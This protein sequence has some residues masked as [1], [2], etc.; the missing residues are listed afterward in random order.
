MSDREFHLGDVLSVTTGILVSPSGKL[1]GPWDLVNHMT[2]DSLFTHQLPRAFDECAPEL[3]RQHPDL[4]AVTVPEMEPEQV[5]SW[6]AEQVAAFG[7]YRSV[8]PLAAEDH[9]RIDP[10]A[11]LRMMRPD[12]PIIA[13]T[14]HPTP[15]RSD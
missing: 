4:A 12:M 9:T 1:D 13:V 7:E 6:L 5:D 10:I 8:Q 2:G 14:P 3:L 11:E 15:P